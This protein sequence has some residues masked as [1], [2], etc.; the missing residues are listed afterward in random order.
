MR[1]LTVVS[2]RYGSRLGKYLARSVTCRLIKGLL[3]GSGRDADR[4]HSIF[5]AGDV[6]IIMT[7]AEDNMFAMSVVDEESK[8]FC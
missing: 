2:R 5:A 4:Q 1:L 3:R 6:P 8:S 7:S